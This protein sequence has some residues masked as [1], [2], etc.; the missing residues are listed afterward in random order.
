LTA[1]YTDQWQLWWRDPENVQLF[2]FMGKDNVVYHSCIF[3]GSQ[4]GTCDR[5]TMVHHLSATEYLT[6]EGGK[7]SKSRGIGVFGDSAQ[8]SGVASDVWRYHLLSH[9]PETGDTDFT[10]DSLIASNNTLLK[11]LGNFLNRVLKFVASRHFNSIIPDRGSYH[12]PSF[13]AWKVEVDRLLSRY[14]RE[15]DAVK[16]RAGAATILQISD[17]GNLFLQSHGLN[18]KLAEEKPAKC[19]AV[20]SYALNLAHLLAA[21]VAPYL[22]T[23]A[24]SICKQLNAEMIPIPDHWNADT[25]KPGHKIGAPQLLFSQ[26]RPEQAEKWRA[27]YG[28]DQL[29]QAKTEEASKRAA[30][31]AAKKSRTKSARTA[32]EE[33]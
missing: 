18:N 25:L 30:K 2:Q 7:F 10:W 13:D 28:G 19:A 26:I 12:E 17:Q 14:I 5:W 31:K 15:L 33:A 9:R 22:P 20:V 8:K 21:L 27:E 16:L 3:P 24:D 6:Y 32:G 29:T 1:N 23:T 11:N 4:I